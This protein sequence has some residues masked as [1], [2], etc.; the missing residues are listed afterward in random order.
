MVV[1]VGVKGLGEHP[2]ETGKSMVGQHEGRKCR[3]AGCG[4]GMEVG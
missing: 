4:G 2:L 1:G 3:N